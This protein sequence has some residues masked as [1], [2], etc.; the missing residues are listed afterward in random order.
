M[1]PQSP[2]RKR[3]D[4]IERPEKIQ[5]LSTGTFLPGELLDLQLKIT[6]KIKK[7]RPLLKFG[8]KIA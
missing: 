4:C 6:R 7:M 1:E 5:Q 2:H 3:Q 8:Y